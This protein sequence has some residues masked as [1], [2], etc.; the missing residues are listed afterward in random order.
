MENKNG[1]V[2]MNS[3]EMTER[4]ISDFMELLADC[5]TDESIRDTRADGY[6]LI[7]SKLRNLV[8]KVALLAQDEGIGEP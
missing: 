1:K 5:T 7:E 2:K 6:E 4:L 3:L 8:N